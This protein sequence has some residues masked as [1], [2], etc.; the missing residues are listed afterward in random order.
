[1]FRHS[2]LAI[3]GGLLLALSQPAMC[4]LFTGPSTGLGTTLY[5]FAPNHNWDLSGLSLVDT[6]DGMKITGSMSA[7]VTNADPFFD[8]SGVFLSA[9]RPLAPGTD[10]NLTVLAHQ[11]GTVSSTGG[12]NVTQIST[13]TSILYSPCAA[14]T[15]FDTG[16][17]Y[18]IGL[19]GS[20][21]AGPSEVS[22]QATL[23][24]NSACVKS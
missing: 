10:L 2:K 19:S 16:G 1:M 5:L 24:E 13:G 21:A 22:C 20:L 11:T 9:Y 23:F 15:S 4:S 14:G 12:I 17:N 7:T 18:E 8:V 6:P 3:F